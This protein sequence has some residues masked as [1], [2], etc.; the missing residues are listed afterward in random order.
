MGQGEGN[1]TRTA[2]GESSL[3]SRCCLSSHGRCNYTGNTTSE[4]Q[5]VHGKFTAGGEVLYNHYQAT[6]QGIIT[7]F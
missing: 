7:R 4:L 5:L 1:P 6:I 3:R 2:A